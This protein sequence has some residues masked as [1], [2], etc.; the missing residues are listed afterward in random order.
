MSDANDDLGT[1]QAPYRVVAVIPVHERL[2]LLPHTISRLYR[3]NGVHKVICVGDGM[4]EKA[5]CEQFGA[6]WVPF[7]NKPLGAKW[8]AG[9]IAARQFNADAVLYVGSSDWLS[10][11]WITTMKPLVNQHQMVGVPGCHFI[12][13]AHKLRLVYWPGY[14]GERSNET[15]GI[16]RMLSKDLLDKINW[17]P[18]DDKKDSS[19]DRSM[20]DRAE[21]IGVKEYFVKND[22]LKAL[23]ISTYK[24]INKHKFEMHWNNQ[25]PSEKIE[26]PSLFINQFFP[27]I[28]HIF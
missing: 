9:F 1:A 16:G 13:I 20:K 27:E 24:W 25:L 4:A 26:D 14:T 8:N 3:K 22:E 12:D 6:Y 11:N 10:D 2:E 21:R 7:Q 15:I 28:N 18:F 23:S 5:I 17:T 19:L